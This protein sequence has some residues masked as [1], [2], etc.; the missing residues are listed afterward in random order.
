MR[1]NFWQWL[2]VILL[3]IGLV[4]IVTRQTSDDRATPPPP[5]PDRLETPEL[6]EPAGPA[7]IAPPPP[8][9]TQPVAP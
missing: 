5:A 8:P 2:G 4:L 3:A 7:E 9:T 1:L 6:A